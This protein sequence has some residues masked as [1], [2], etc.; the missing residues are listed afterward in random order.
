MNNNDT[1]QAICNSLKE[2][3]FKKDAALLAGISEATLY[4]WI[5]EDESFDSRVEASVLEYKRTLIRN[6]TICAEKD[7]R[8]A[9]EV[10]KRRFPKEWGDKINMLERSQDLNRERKDVAALLQKIYDRKEASSQIET[11]IALPND[12]VNEHL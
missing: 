8:L 1:K 11:V 4:R 5:E 10:L 3:M 7:G 12:H 2:G 6:V 9:L